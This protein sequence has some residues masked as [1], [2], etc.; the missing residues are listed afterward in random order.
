MEIY[1]HPSQ[2][3]FMAGIET[4]L[5]PLYSLKLNKQINKYGR[6]KERNKQE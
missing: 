4:L 2:Y 3:T 1:L 5:P 6:K